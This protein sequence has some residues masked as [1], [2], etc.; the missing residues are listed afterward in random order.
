MAH[1]AKVESELEAHPDHAVIESW[2]RVPT[3]MLPENAPGTFTNIVL[4]YIQ[5]RRLGR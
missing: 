2:V 3:K 1:F 5:T 4:Q